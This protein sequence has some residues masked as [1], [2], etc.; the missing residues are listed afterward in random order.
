MYPRAQL[1]SRNIRWI[2]RHVLLR[3]FIQGVDYGSIAFNDILAVR[4][5]F[6][7]ALIGVYNKHFG[8][9]DVETVKKGIAFQVVVDEGRSCTDAV[10]RKHQHQELGAI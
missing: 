10:S 2:R 4:Y 8:I 5:P 6:L 3:L 9:A 7:A 1:V